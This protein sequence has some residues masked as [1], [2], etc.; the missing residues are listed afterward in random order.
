M[1]VSNKKPSNAKAFLVSLCDGLASPYTLF[2]PSRGFLNVKSEDLVAKAWQ[3]VGD[4]LWHA[5]DCE[6]Q[7]RSKQQQLDNA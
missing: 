4:A 6:D 7:A 2:F 5:M 1:S 3:N